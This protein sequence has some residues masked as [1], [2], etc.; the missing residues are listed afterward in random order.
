[1]HFRRL[2]STLFFVLLACGTAHA[3]E[4]PRLEHQGDHWT[5]I[6]DGKPYFPLGAQVGNSSG[7][8]ERL[9]ELWPL[10]AAMHVN[11]L[12]VPVY[13]EQLEPHEGTF[14]DSAVDGIIQQAREHHV[15][16]VLLW[17]GTWKNGKMHYVPDWVKRDQTR[18]P[19]MIDRGG[20][21]IDVLSAN[22]PANLDADR[23]AFTHL[24]HRVKQT[25]TL[26]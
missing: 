12:E 17:F 19:R 8:P 18:F 24:M 20:H 15:R 13:W 3:E 16:L 21:P 10:A 9:S 22:A 6:V 2:T 7:W 25:S 23:K 11:T 1:M 26:R 5:F 4:L 14:D